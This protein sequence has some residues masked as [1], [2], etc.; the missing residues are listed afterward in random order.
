MGIS[1]LH[2]HSSASY[3]CF[4]SIWD[5]CERA[6]ALGL[7]AVAFTEHVE[8][9]PEE[10]PRNPFDYHKA[11]ETWE[12]VQEAYLGTLVVLFG[13][14]VTY[15]P[16]LEDEIGRYLE[17][18]PFDI[19]MGSVHQAPVIDFWHERNARIVKANPGMAREALKV[20]LSHTEKLASSGLFDVVGHFGVYERRMPGIWPEIFGDEELEPLLISALEA[21]VQN[22]RLEVNAAVLHKPGHFPAPR[23]EVLKLYREMGG[24]PP[25]FG[26]DAHHAPAV[27][28][29]WHMAREVVR[30]AGFSDFAH[31]S[32]VFN[33]NGPSYRAV[34]QGTLGKLS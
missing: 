24:L 12:K 21:I 2:M 3:D 10:F 22:S 27:G 6:A 4:T 9:N 17:D 5:M 16:H 30:Q 28:A 13:A 15:W 25:V 11:R 19:V 31:W 32:E 1:D 34:Q 33:P 26:S 20:Y 7:E 14:E 23:V 18:H 8:L 29:N